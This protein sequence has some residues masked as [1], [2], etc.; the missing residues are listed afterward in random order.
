[1]PK[2]SDAE[3][4]LRRPAL[5]L[6]PAFEILDIGNTTGFKWIK[7]GILDRFY[8]DDIPYVTTKSIRR[9]M[10]VGEDA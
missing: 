8:I 2:N 6:G 4:L 3:A 5:R 9:V 7:A 1:M 10:R